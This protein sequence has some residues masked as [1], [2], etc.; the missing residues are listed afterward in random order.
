MPKQH[1]VNLLLDNQHLKKA[2]LHYLSIDNLT[3]RQCLKIKSS[4]V[5][6][7]NHLNKVHPSF[8]Q[9]YKK[10]SPEFCLGGNFPNCF[11]FHIANYKI[12]KS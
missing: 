4:I 8:N 7:T 3:D 6:T 9:L 11:S 5:D 2:K 10:L 12:L 1:V